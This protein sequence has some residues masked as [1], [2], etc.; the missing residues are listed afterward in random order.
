MALRLPLLE[1]HVANACN[2]TCES[3]SHFSNSGHKGMLSLADAEAWMKSW[4][5]RVIP[6]LFRMLGGEPT[7]NPHLPALI[8]LAARYWTQSRIG[9]TTNGFFL[10][11]HPDLPAV[12]E[13][14]NVILRL[15]IH[16]RSEEYL[17]KFREIV[18]IIDE[19]RKDYSFELVVE[20]AYDRWTRRYHGFGAGVLPFRDDNPRKSWENCPAKNCMQ[21]FR[22]R[23]WKCSPIAYLRLQKESHPG[24]S[25]LW[26]RYLAYSGLGPDCSDA[27]L[28]TFTQWQDEG[29]CGMCAMTPKP[30]EKPSPLIPLSVLK[31]A[32]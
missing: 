31:T 16:H 27:E 12:L 26:D 29:I 15:T 18:S 1:I 11:R 4:H 28:L 17:A 30:F 19:W 10:H 3:C 24:I 14:H 9:L 13:R 6:G 5:T 8:E 32:A 25:R 23:L 20:N 22:N 2:L 7:L 21:L